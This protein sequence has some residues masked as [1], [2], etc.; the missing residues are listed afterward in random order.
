MA[1]NEVSISRREALALGLVVAAEGAALAHGVSA[2]TAFA[3]EAAEEEEFAQ[4][5]ETVVGAVELDC[6]SEMVGA[7]STEL[8]KWIQTSVYN[9]EAQDEIMA[10]LDAAKD[11]QTLADPLVAYNPFG[12]NTLS[13]YVYFTTEEEASVSYTISVAE[14]DM[15]VS[16]SKKVAEEETAEEE[17][18]SAL[19]GTA[20]ALGEAV[21][22]ETEAEEDAYETYDVAIDDRTREVNDGEAALEH[23]FQVIGLVPGV[24]NTVRLTATY[25]DGSLEH[26]DLTCAVGSL[27]G[28]E[29]VQLAV[30]D[31]ESDTDLSEGLYVI[32]GNGASESDFM[33][34][35][36]NQGVVRG[37]M[38]VNGYRPFRMIYDDEGSLYYCSA[39]HEM[40]VMSALGQVTRVYS[41]G[42]YSVHHDYVW[43]AEGQILILVTDSSRDDSS[44]DIVVAL[45][46]ETGEVTEVIDMGDL[47]PSFKEEVF[48]SYQSSS[49]SQSGA[50]GGMGANGMGTD[51]IV[52]GFGDMGDMGDMG[53][54]GDMDAGAA[55]STIAAVN[56]IDADVNA[57]GDLATPATTATTS[58]DDVPGWM[59]I[60]CLQYI[61]ED[62]AV[63][64][65]SRETSTIFKVSGI[66]TEPVID[67][68][69][70]SEL[71]W[72]GTDYEDLV[73]A[74]VGDFTVHGGQHCLNYVT[75]DELEEGQ[76]YLKFFNN[77]YGSASTNDFDYEGAGIGLEDCSYY[78][79]YLVDE[80]EGT[81]ELVSSLAVPSSSYVSSVQWKDGNLIVDSGLQGLYTEY[82]ADY[83]PIRSFSVGDG[84]SFIYRSFKYD[85]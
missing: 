59:H 17:D 42:D 48:A 82:D 6:A 80:N 76:Y 74:Q 81:F 12:T 21:T 7:E 4:T 75:D 65:S 46:I 11:G 83:N 18:E 1:S 14:E 77:N 67:Y 9:E 19:E 23:E 64:L 69:L 68:M 52:G 22:D 51:G 61:A 72:A 15:T 33:Y 16:I 25:E 79:E 53:G 71:F 41:L 54:F 66:S 29:S 13:L 39:E 26:C 84:E 56:D 34:L 20:V 31:G 38:T 50:M 8:E 57:D 60:N 85:L 40:S 3:D 78:Y 35:R 55:M 10:E 37:E 32:L 43:G 62:D 45:D 63:L 28:D 73:F 70:A 27:I 47:L 5:S 2:S 49:S 58:T 24:T 30:E 44:E 36:D